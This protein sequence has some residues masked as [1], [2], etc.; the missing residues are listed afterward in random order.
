MIDD[1]KKDLISKV[2]DKKLVENFFYSYEEISKEFVSRDPIGLFQ[3]V[4]L[5]IE[6]SFRIIEHIIFNQHTPLTSNLSIDNL[7][8]KQRMGT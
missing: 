3:N 1:I 2:R 5:F 8:K 4:G 6:S 7:I